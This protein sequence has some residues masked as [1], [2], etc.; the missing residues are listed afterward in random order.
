[1]TDKIQDNLVQ[2]PNYTIVR[3]DRQT[4]KRGGGIIVYINKHTPYTTVPPT[5][6]FSNED[7]ECLTIKLSPPYQQSYYITTVYIPPKA[8]V[9]T[10]I[11]TL[12]NLY[13]VLE[14]D[15]E[16]W[17]LGGDFNINYKQDP[18]HEKSTNKMKINA[19]H[20]LERHCV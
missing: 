1:M 7:I 19:L 12:I 2:I 16:T 15:R 18:E 11:N 13:D 4:P 14:I 17:I 6:N 10:A 9:T 8:D 20:H 5:Q 3:L